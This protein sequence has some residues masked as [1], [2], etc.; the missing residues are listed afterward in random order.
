MKSRILGMGA[1]AISIAFASC[2]K[3]LDLLPSDSITQANVFQS[4]GDLEQGLIGVYGS[5][6]GENNMYYGAILADE[7]KISNENRGQ[8][9]FDFKWEIT[10]DGAPS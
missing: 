7:A 9:P 5:A 3:Q 4:V 1:V 10:S 6:N 8:G 2:D